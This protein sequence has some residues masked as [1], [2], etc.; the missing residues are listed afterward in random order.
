MYYTKKELLGAIFDW[1]GSRYV[2]IEN[3]E[4]VQIKSLQSGELHPSYDSGFLNAECLYYLV[5]SSLN[6]MNKIYYY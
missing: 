6:R 1:S 5:K 2:V 3:G 4:D